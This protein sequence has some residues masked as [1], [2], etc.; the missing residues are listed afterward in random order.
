MDEE[1]KEGPPIGALYD[2]RGNRL[3]LVPCLDIIKIG[4]AEVKAG[5]SEDGR[6]TLFQ[7]NMVDNRRRDAVQTA[8]K[9]LKNEIT[10]RKQESEALSKEIDKLLETS[11]EDSANMEDISAQMATKL[12]LRAKHVRR[13]KELEST[14][15]TTVSYT[16]VSGSTASLRPGLVTAVSFLDLPVIWCPNALAEERGGQESEVTVTVDVLPS[17][18]IGPKVS[19]ILS[20]GMLETI[21][22]MI[23]DSLLR[24]KTGVLTLLHTSA[25]GQDA[26]TFDQ[27]VKNK[28]LVLIV[29]KATTGF[30]FGGFVADQF[31]SSGSWIAGS[32][33]NF[34]YTLGNSNL[35]TP[36]SGGNKQKPIVAK[37]A[38][39]PTAT[40]GIH[41]TSCGLHMGSSGALVAF[42]SHSTVFPNADYTL[43]NGFE[44]VVV[45]GN[46]VAGCSSSFT[47]EFMEVYQVE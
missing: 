30:V 3:A 18:S 19:K 26:S 25:A 43:A 13:I 38:K 24:S 12:A 5:I 31:G 37:F 16:R 41:I 17:L 9:Q 35:Y 42:C 46:T 28:E 7:H 33:F 29:I 20:E 36:Q 2:V 47:P 11:E 4:E 1:K 6:L 44:S 23:D 15:T 32:P 45:D 8:Q 39:N 34:I 21:T 40:Q 27:K 14:K 10:R 22:R